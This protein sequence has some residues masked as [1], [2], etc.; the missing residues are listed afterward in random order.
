MEIWE[1]EAGIR[2]LKKIGLNTDQSVLD[3]GTGIGH[4]SIPAAYIVGNN[5]VVYAIDKDK[6]K[7]DQ[8]RQKVIM[9][10]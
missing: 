8:L 2:F 4:Y 5:G 1:K 7:L 10:K 3:F 6:E 9:V